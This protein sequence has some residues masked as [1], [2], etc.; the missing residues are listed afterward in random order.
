MPKNSFGFTVPQAEYD[1][2]RPLMPKDDAALLTTIDQVD[3]SPVWNSAE[4]R[5][6]Y[7]K[8]FYST[9]AWVMRINHRIQ[10]SA[11]DVEGRHTFLWTPQLPPRPVGAPLS[12]SRFDYASQDA[13]G[14]GATDAFDGGGVLPAGQGIQSGALAL[15]AAVNHP[16]EKRR[17]LDHNDKGKRVPRQVGPYG[18]STA[19]NT[20]PV[21]HVHAQH[22]GQPNHVAT[23]APY[24]GP[25]GQQPPT[26]RTHA[27]VVQKTPD[28]QYRLELP[29]CQPPQ[30]SIPSLSN[31]SCGA[32]PS[33]VMGPIQSLP[34][35]RPA[36]NLT[37]SP[38]SHDHAQ[39][40]QGQDRSPAA[41]LNDVI[42]LVT[43]PPASRQR[44]YDQTRQATSIVQCA[45]SPDDESARVSAAKTLV[46]MFKQAQREVLH[47]DLLEN[48][49]A[50]KG[51][52]KNSK[53]GG[54]E[55]KKPCMNS[56]K[57]EEL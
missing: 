46:S 36:Q 37:S 7:S 11:Y 27:A 25:Y 1:A 48:K 33:R 15:A 35:W 6:W 29:A 26:L 42:D 39:P 20:I 47:T 22:P 53:Q 54:G 18:M 10:C 3:K 5:Q 45:R 14:K 55:A 28:D 51:K 50:K 23:H 30:T 40:V 17:G 4:H 9:V 32:P 16:V 56:K 44:P 57:D 21:Q 13:I 38:S 24:S 31:G 49:P 43:Q 2:C 34:G 41:L 19:P 12:V 8:G 52:H